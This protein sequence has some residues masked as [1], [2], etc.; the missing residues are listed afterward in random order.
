[1]QAPHVPG[2]PR[3]DDTAMSSGASK[4]QQSWGQCNLMRDTVPEGRTAEKALLSPI[5][6]KTSLLPDLMG[7]VDVTG[8]IGNNQ[9]LA[10]RS[11]LATNAVYEAD[12]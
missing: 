4:G 1:M 7:Q 5:E 10:T 11:K 3:R 12:V 8:F 9:H 2:I 6:W